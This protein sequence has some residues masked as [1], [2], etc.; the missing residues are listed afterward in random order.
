MIIWNQDED[1]QLLP[2][3]CHLSAK[4]EVCMKMQSRIKRRKSL[5]IVILEQALLTMSMYCGVWHSRTASNDN[6]NEH[7]S[8]ALL[9]SMLAANKKAAAVPKYKVLYAFLHNRY[10]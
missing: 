8:V 3:I 10:V 1:I 5:K 2:I 7:N 4:V 9:P 6:I